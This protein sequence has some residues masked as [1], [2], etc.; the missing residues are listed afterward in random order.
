M[1]E[2]KNFAFKSRIY[3]PDD[4]SKKWFVEYYAPHRVR[5][6]GDINKYTTFQSRLSAA[7]KLQKKILTELELN[8]ADP[9][10]DKLMYY[11]SAENGLSEATMIT[12]TSV[13]QLFFLSM[14]GKAVSR[15]A[16]EAY[17]YEFGAR[18]SGAS[19]NKHITVLLK[20]FRKAGCE[21]YFENIKRVKVVSSPARYFQAYQIEQLADHLRATDTDLLY[22]CRC[23]FYLFARP[24]EV[25]QQQP[26]NVYLDEQKI[27]FPAKISKNKKSMFCRVPDVFMSEIE[28]SVRQ[29]EMYLFPAHRTK[30]KPAGKNTYGERMRKVLRSLSYPVGY[31]IYSWKHTGVVTAKKGGADVKDIMMQCRH[32]SLDETDRYLR[33]LGV[34]DMSKFAGIMPPI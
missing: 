29:S 12:Y 34:K 31:S 3:S 19:F 13:I 33:Q 17:F 21:H 18:A 8:Y 7:K 15:D 2:K 9:V 14:R 5:K 10:Y 27:L 16:V 26:Y 24:N 6:Y 22:F 28:R 1:T 32:S 30:F 11:L 4:L 25:R 23:L 20:Y